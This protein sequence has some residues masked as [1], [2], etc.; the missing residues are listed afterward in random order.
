MALGKLSGIVGNLRLDETNSVLIRNNPS[1][2][3]TR[4]YVES[5]IREMVNVEFT[6]RMNVNAQKNPMW[7]RSSEE[8]ALR[9]KNT[10]ME[11]FECEPVQFRDKMDMEFEFINPNIPFH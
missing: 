10:F 3:P 4:P 7:F 1:Y 2:T 8:T 6:T 11:W 9:D 5:M